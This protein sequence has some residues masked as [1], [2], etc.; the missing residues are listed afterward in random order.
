MKSKIIIIILSILLIISL[1]FN[2]ILIYREL[3]WAD[4]DWFDPMNELH[5]GNMA[6][7]F[8]IPLLTGETFT[9]SENKGQ[10]VVLDFWATWCGPCVEKMPTIQILSEKYDNV[11]FVGINVGEDPGMVQDFISRMNFSY[12]I[13]L[14][15]DSHLIMNLYPTIAIPYLV[16][17]NGDGIIAET[18]H[19]GS[20]LMKEIIEE[21]II[22][23]LN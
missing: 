14:D 18:I 1:A 20:S 8:S 21:A 23:A 12:H 3:R 7:D 17:I 19:G 11:V 10:V 5:A 9:L 2:A 6:P 16:I 15:E 22:N 4:P 13:G